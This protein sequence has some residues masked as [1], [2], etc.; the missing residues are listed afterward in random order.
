MPKK[1]PKEILKILHKIYPDLKYYL[2]LSNPNPLQILIG[3]ILSAQVRDEVVN[4]TT[5][6]L[7]RKYKTAEDFAL[8]DIKELTAMIKNI[9][10][11]NNKAKYIKEA[12]TILVRKYHGKVPQNE[13]EL[14]ELP[15]IGRKT[16][17][18]ILQNAFNIVNG[19]VVDTHVLRIAYR[20]GWATTDKNADVSETQ[21]MQCIPKQEWKTLPWI[22]KA[23]GRLICKAPVPFC[24]KCPISAFCQK[25][26]VKK[27][28]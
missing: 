28:Y 13:E 7:F 1:E 23:H 19:I 11:A 20:V 21:L 12:C 25:N 22:L 18:A 24:S 27:N 14:R 26:G 3:T 2:N 9:T 8:A 17:N 5:P 10:F 6:A 15:G 4:T 16:A